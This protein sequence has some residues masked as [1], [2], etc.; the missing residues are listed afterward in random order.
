MN[1]EKPIFLFLILLF[2]FTHSFAET[3]VWVIRDQLTSRNRIDSIIT[4]ATKY[5]IKDL[6]VQVRGRGRTCYKSQYE[7]LEFENLSFDPLAYFL[8]KAH[9]KELRVHAWLNVFLVWS[10]REKPKEVNHPFNK[11]NSFL[12][13]DLENN[14]IDEIYS[15]FIRRRKVEG[16]Y[17]SPASPEVQKYL[18]D[19][20][21]ELILKYPIDGVHLDYFRYPRNNFVLDFELLNFIS[22]KYDIRFSS[23]LINHVQQGNVT[24]NERKKI[25]SVLSIPLTNF[26]KKLHEWVN[27]Y[28]P[29]VFISVAVKGD[30]DRAFLEYYQNWEYWIKNDLVDFV[31]PMVYTNKMDEFNFSTYKIASRFDLNKTWI[32]LG[33]FNKNSSQL[34]QQMEHLKKLRFPNTVFF[35]YKY[36]KKKNWNTIFKG[37]KYETRN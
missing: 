9:Q 32:G 23:L 22:N 26:L 29:N 21:K 37:E 18:L 2:L 6:F 17:L 30:P 31:C 11:F 25:A 13:K 4:F 14:K 35:S 34:I 1:K 27:K 7:N 19:L 28:V 24:L 16:Y 15:K 10:K 36:M 20:L 3:G 5:G 8:E 12:I 33:V